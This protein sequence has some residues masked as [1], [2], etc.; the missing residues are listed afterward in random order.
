MRPITVIIFFLFAGLFFTCAKPHLAAEQEPDDNLQIPLYQCKSVSL[1][2]DATI[3]FDSLLTDSR[4]PV[5]VDCVWEGFAAG[6]FSL[7]TDFAVHTFKLATMDLPGLF[8][9]DT[10]VAGYKIEF[11]NLTPYPGTVSEPV[12]DNVRKAELRVTK[13]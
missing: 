9:K 11:I 8:S 13:L 2:S 6:K 3:C 12:P 10:I 1:A 7:T 5:Y 4:C